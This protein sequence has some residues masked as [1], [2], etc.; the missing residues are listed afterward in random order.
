M[1]GI[2][3]NLGSIKLH[4]FMLSLPSFDNQRL[5]LHAA[6]QT[7]RKAEMA[8]LIMHEWL[9][10]HESELEA[11]KVKIASDLGISVG[12]LEQQLMARAE[13]Q[14][15]PRKRKDSDDSEM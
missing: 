14:A 15:R 10:Q 3:R 9:E 2:N 8:R 4:R 7:L 12:E 1:K 11:W 5:L 6:R 13:D